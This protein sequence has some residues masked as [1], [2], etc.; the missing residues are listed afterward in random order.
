MKQRI[1]P[2]IALVLLPVCLCTSQILK[3]EQ[4]AE[5][6]VIER[7]IA[8]E[9][10][11][12]PIYE[13]TVQMVIQQL[14]STGEIVRRPDVLQ[15]LVNSEAL[16]QLAIEAR[17]DDEP[18]TNSL[19]QLQRNS[20]LSKA[21]LANLKDSIVVTD[22]EID[23]AYEA[24]K[25]HSLNWEYNAAHILLSSEQKANLVIDKLTEGLDFTLAAE[26]YSEGPSKHKGGDLG[27]FAESVMDPAFA[28]ATAALDIGSF[29][30]VPVQSSFG[31]HVIYLK[32]KR[33]I[34]IRTQ[35]S[36][37]SDIIEQI[38]AVKLDDLLQ[39]ALEEIVI[40]IR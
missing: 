28:K 30:A 31:W 21:Y 6:Q 40:D 20:I 25:Q 4:E 37:R 39:S 33:Q 34:N 22:D 10:N 23:A 24:Y 17:I 1:N 12:V 5:I 19:L 36:M 26:T 29:N 14:E 13:S 2:T 3:A 35:E 15:E 27:W 7:S 9:V 32:N 18:V 38:T 16:S 11:G 8:A